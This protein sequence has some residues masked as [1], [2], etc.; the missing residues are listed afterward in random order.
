MRGCSW[1]PIRPLMAPGSRKRPLI[2]LDDALA[3]GGFQTAAEPRGPVGRTERPD[4]GPVVDALLT[5]IGPLDQG[6]TGSQHRRELALQGPERRLR[7]RLGLLRRDLNHI[8]T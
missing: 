3:A 4:H 2:P 5:Q 7:V 1:G 6:R 8:A